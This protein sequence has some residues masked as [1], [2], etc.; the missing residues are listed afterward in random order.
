MPGKLA[1]NWTQARRSAITPDP[2]DAGTISVTKSNTYIRFAT[3]AAAETGTI[4]DPYSEG[5]TL[6]LHCESHG[7]GDRTYTASTGIDQA[8]TTS[9][10][11]GADDDFIILYSV[12]DG[13][14]FRWQRIESDG[15]G[16]V[17]SL[18]D[19]NVALAFGTSSDVSLKWDGTDFDVTALADDTVMKIGTGTLSFDAWLYGNTANS[20]VLWDASADTLSL[21]GPARTKGFN[22]ISPR[23]ELHWVAGQRGKPGINADILNASEAVRM[24]ADPDFEI[25]GTN[26]TSD[27]VT[28]NAEGGIKI[29][30]DTADGDEVIILPHLDANQT[31][32]EQVTWG[33]DQSVIWEAHIKTGS[34]ITNTI[35]WAGL[36]LTNTEVKATDADQ[37]FF[38]YE[39]DVAAGNWEVVDS[40]ADTDVSTDTGVVGAVDTEVH[41]KIVIGSDRIAKCYLNGALVR[42]TTALTDA[43]DLKPYIGVAADGAGAAKHILVF[44]Q[45]ISRAYA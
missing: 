5:L 3:G 19:D 4:A 30:T 11:F 8:G 28:F 7:G 10:V 29:E 44:G 43:I 45:S 18:Y 24:V 35:I 21:E 34:N 31:A 27:D 2:G 37:V 9:L 13:S 38:R 1:T 17:A 22:T 23:F 12:V 20:Y 42:T 32:W 33:T 14:D 26:A 6:A 40:I 15:L 39:D 36:K 16:V 25:L 41:L